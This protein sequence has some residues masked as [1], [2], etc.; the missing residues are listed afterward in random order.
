MMGFFFLAIIINI[1]AWILARNE[2]M[3]IKNNFTKS[4]D[5]LKDVIEKLYEQNYKLVKTHK[6]KEKH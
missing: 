1:V 3:R 4:T 6:A 2:L 5:E